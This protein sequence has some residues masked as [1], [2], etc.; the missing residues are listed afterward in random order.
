MST[1]RT[2]RE[3][4]AT[5]EAVFDAIRDPVRLAR[6]WGP[7]DFRN[8]FETFEFRPG[9]SWVFTMHGP[10][11]TNYP[12]RST[13]LEIVPGALVKLRHVVPPHFELTLAL[14]PCT[15]GTRVDWTQAFEDPA[16]AARVRTIVVPANEE[17]LDRL[18]AEVEDVL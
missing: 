9:G 8:T 11:G 14:T 7:K 15:A 6:W 2:S 1:F 10:D 4:K 3:L 5:P 17:N 16:V 18:A 13:F 12:N